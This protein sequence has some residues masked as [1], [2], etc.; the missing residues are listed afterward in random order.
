M[1]IPLDHDILLLMKLRKFSSGME[2]GKTSRNIAALDVEQ[3]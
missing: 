1:L 2:A 3:P